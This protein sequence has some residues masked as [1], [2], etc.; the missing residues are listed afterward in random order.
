[1]LNLLNNFIFF[2]LL[3]YITE[4]FLIKLYKK[5]EKI[6]FLKNTNILLNECYAEIMSKFNL[7]EIAFKNKKEIQIEKILEIRESFQ[8][9]YSSI[10]DSLNVNFI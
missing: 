2:C 8:I 3:V 5:M 1:M 10:T 7:V 9:F 6:N 4:E